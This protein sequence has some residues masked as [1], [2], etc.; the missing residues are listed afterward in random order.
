MK[1]IFFPVS[2][3]TLVLIIAGI[4]IFHS[5]VTEK[6]EFLSTFEFI[7]V[8]FILIFF[9]IGNVFWIKRIK[10]GKSGLP[11]EDEL[12]K[13]ISQK[14][15]A[16]SFYISLFIWLILL[17][18][19]QSKILQTEILFGIGFIAMAITFITTWLIFNSRGIGNE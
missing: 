4:R 18:I 15:S 8:A 14:S 12:S 7:H 11:E 10:S 3:L 16:F 13:R 1:K 17:F 6:S 2:I 19:M 9:F 5:G